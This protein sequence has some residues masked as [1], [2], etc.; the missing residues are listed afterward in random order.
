DRLHHPGGPGGRRAGGDQRLPGR[1]RRAEPAAGEVLGDRRGPVRLLHAG[2]ADVGRRAAPLRREGHAREGARA[3][4]RQPLPVH[5]LPGDR[6]RRGR[7]GGG[8][9]DPMTETVQHRGAET[10]RVV[11]TEVK[12][13]DSREKLLGKTRYAGDFDIAGQLYAKLVRAPMPSARIVSKDASAAME[14][15]GVVA[16]FFGERSEEHTSELQSRENVVCR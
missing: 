2:D 7:G 14:V 6:E 16:V 12:R 5:R 15:P 3:P 13:Q 10:T 9:G 11:N 4:A 8:G 1:R